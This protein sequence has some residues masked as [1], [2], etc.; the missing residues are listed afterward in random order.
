MNRAEAFGSG[1]SCPEDEALLQAYAKF[2][3]RLP[4]V[5]RV[6]HH[7]LL[8][9]RHLLKRLQGLDC[10]DSSVA[11][12]LDGLD[13]DASRFIPYLLLFGHLQPGYHYL[14]SHRFSSLLRESAFSPLA[15]DVVAV[16]EAA[17]QLGY[18]RQ[19][20]ERCSTMVVLRILV[21][22]GKH[23]HALTRADLD[24]FRGA[25]AA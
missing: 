25:A 6:R 16:Q 4:L 20:I 10:Y 5:P 9:A 19:R 21:Q 24:E 15:E 11:A 2:L 1:R 22:T 17:K 13:Q 23:L 18:S 12:A 7:R 14:F 8:G 3:D